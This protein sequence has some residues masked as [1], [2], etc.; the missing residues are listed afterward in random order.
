MAESLQKKRGRVRPPRVHITYDVE[1]NGAIEKKELPFV[2]GIIADLSHQPN[3]PLKPL[4]ERKFIKLTK[5]NLDSVMASQDVH[6]ALRVQDKL[7]DKDQKLS[8]NLNFNSMDDFSPARVAE[9]VPA[10]KELMDIRQRLAQLKTKLVNN[11]KLENLLT[12]VLS[13]TDMAMA[14]AKEKGIETPGSTTPG[15]QPEETK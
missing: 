12:E 6:V 15:S 14:L 9:Q 7:T 11:D 8:V 5:E 13:N 3:K 4:K 1:T 10:L 2:V